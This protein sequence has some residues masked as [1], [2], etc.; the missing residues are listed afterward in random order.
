MDVEWWDLPVEH[1]RGSPQRLLGVDVF[2]D[3]AWSDHFPD[4]RV[5]FKDGQCASLI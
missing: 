3:F 4:N 2:Y 5:Q 1:R